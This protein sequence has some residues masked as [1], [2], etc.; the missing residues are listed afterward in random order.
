M[1]NCNWD[2]NRLFAR[3]LENFVKQTIEYTAHYNPENCPILFYFIFYL[4]NKQARIHAR[5][6]KYSAKKSGLIWNPYMCI[7]NVLEC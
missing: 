5:Y 2:K 3:N 6:L 4:K 1:N 7:S